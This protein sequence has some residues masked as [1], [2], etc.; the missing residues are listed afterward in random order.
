MALI[1]S[2]NNNSGNFLRYVFNTWQE[3]FILKGQGTS[4]TVLYRLWG[5]QEAP[6]FQHSL[7]MKVVWLSALWI[8][9][10]FHPGNFP[11]AHFCHRLSRTQGHSAAGRKM[12][13]KNSTDTMENRTFWIVAQCPKQL[14]YC[15]SQSFIAPNEF[16]QASLQQKAI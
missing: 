5:F 1:F 16:Y 13:V 6:K 2:W 12:S 4:I 8:G 10:L 14:R 7:H 15:V 9:C 11:D 3:S